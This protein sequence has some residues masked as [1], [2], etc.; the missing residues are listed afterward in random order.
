[1]LS[2]SCKTGLTGEPVL[3]MKMFEL[4]G[5]KA[6]IH[7]Y[8][9]CRHVCAKHGCYS[10]TISFEHTTN[11]DQPEI[12]PIVVLGSQVPEAKFQDECRATLHPPNRLSSSWILNGNNTIRNKKSHNFS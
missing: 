8:I 5:G 11:I 6:N 1:M 9:Q 2:K 3:Y 12:K 7:K 10:G 4:L